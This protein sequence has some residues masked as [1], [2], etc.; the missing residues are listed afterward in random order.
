[1]QFDATPALA[2]RSTTDPI[3][4]QSLMVLKM[5]DF[6]LRDGAKWTQYA[7]ET[8]DGKCCLVGALWI[9]RHEINSDDDRVPEYL[10]QAIRTYRRAAQTVDRHSYRQ[11]L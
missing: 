2:R 10:A 4:E 11:R 1:M 3:A 8:W 9:V 5:I 7:W 6:V